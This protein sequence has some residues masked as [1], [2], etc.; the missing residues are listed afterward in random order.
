MEGDTL[1][2]TLRAVE[3]T[4]VLNGNGTPFVRLRLYFDN[5]VINRELFSEEKVQD[6]LLLMRCKAELPNYPL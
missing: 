1:N 4:N 3:L 2:G 5:T 6:I